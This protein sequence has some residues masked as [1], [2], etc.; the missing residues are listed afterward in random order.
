[1]QN[2]N[3]GYKVQLKFKENVYHF[4]TINAKLVKTI[5]EYWPD[6]G[7]LSFEKCLENLK[8]IVNDFFLPVCCSS[9]MLFGFDRRSL[10]NGLLRLMMLLLNRLP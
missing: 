4:V 1:M 6:K 8:D 7:F 5:F 3:L 10:K 2:C 9:S